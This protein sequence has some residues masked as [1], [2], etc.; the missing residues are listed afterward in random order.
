MAWR[1]LRPAERLCAA[2][3][4]RDCPV[5]SVPLRRSRLWTPVPFGDGRDRHR[6]LVPRMRTGPRESTFDRA[7]RENHCP[8][9]S[10]TTPSDCRSA[11]WP[12]SLT[13][14]LIAASFLLYSY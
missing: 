1:S 8:P 6:L 9:P 4:L 7:R 10:A 14:T 13:S 2:S 3:Q 5:A 12:P 11:H